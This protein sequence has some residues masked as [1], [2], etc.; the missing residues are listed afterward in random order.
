MTSATVRLG[1]LPYMLRT[2]PS[3]VVVPGSPSA[4]VGLL[5]EHLINHC[6]VK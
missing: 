5:H 2:W 6:Q 1:E 4:P 3:V